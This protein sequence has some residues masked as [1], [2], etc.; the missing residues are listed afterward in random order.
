VS[1]RTLQYAFECICGMPPVQYFKRHRLSLARRA[2][3][4]SEPSAGAVKTAAL[5]AGFL[6]LGRFSAEYQAMFGEKPSETLTRPPQ[7]GSRM[8]RAVPGRAL[9]TARM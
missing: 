9:R 7:V 4:R 2:L 3:R 8:P 5:D 6:H 1:A